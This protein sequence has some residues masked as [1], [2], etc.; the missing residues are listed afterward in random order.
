MIL[1][2]RVSGCIWPSFTPGLSLRPVWAKAVTRMSRCELRPLGKG[3]RRNGLEGK[4]RFRHRAGRRTAQP[5][6]DR[7]C[8]ASRARKHEHLG[9]RPFSPR[10]RAT[11]S[12]NNPPTN[13]SAS[14]HRTASIIPIAHILSTTNSS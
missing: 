7:V 6:P 2:H 9:A 8:V 12:Y 4:E 11:S 14:S 13:N 10:S 1:P 3:G 5:S